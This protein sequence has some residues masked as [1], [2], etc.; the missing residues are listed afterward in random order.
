MCY[1]F[2][3]QRWLSITSN[4]PLRLCDCAIFEAAFGYGQEDGKNCEPAEAVLEAG[5]KVV[6]AVEEN[7]R[8]K[9]CYAKAFVPDAKDEKSAKTSTCHVNE[10]GAKDAGKD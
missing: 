7:G 10:V 9:A 6:K 1:I 5:K 2:V 8:Q 4:S 3:G